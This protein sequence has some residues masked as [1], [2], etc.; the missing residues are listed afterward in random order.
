VDRSLEMIVGLLGILKAGGAYVPLDPSYPEE[1]LKYIVKDSGITI[2]LTKSN[3]DWWISKEVQTISLE[4][5]WEFISHGCNINPL[6]EVMPDNLAY[7]IYTSGSTG[8]PKGVLLEQKGLCNLVLTHIELMKVDAKSR[9]IQFASLSFDAAVNEVFTT[10]IAGATLYLCSSN[11]IMPKDPLTQF[12]QHNRITHA[13]LPP[14]VL[15]IL[16]ELDFKHLKVLISAGSACSE[17]IAQRWSKNCL[18]INGYGPTETTVCATIGIYEGNGKPH[19]GRPLPN[20]EVYVLDQNLQLVP[21]GVAGEL[22]IGGIALARGYLN[23]PELTAASFISHPFKG[24]AKAKIYKTGDLVKYLPNGNIEYMERIDNQVKIR[25]FRIELGEIEAVLGQYPSIKEVVVV[26]QDDKIGDKKL[27]AYVVGEGNVQEWKNHIQAHLPSY[28]IPSHF[29]NIESIPLTINGKVDKKSLPEWQHLIQNSKEYIPPRNDVERKLVVI[30]SEVLGI[31][32]SL[33]GVGDSF[34]ELGG[35]SLKIMA[36]LVKTLSEGWDISIKDYYELKTISKIAEKINSGPVNAIALPVS[37][38]Q[39]VKSPKKKI[40]KNK[41]CFDSSSGILLTGSTGYLGVHLLEKLMDATQN[42]IYCVVRGEDDQ[43]AIIRL[44]KMVK[45]YFKDK[46]KKYEALINKRLFIVKGELADKQFGLD[47]VR[48]EELKKQVNIVIHAAAL[49]KHFGDW[50]DFENANVQSVREIL[51]FVGKDKQLHHISTTSVSGEYTSDEGNIFT[52]NDSYIKQNYEDNVY[53]KSKFLAEQE[54][55]KAISEGTDANIY[56]V[57]NLTNRY[58]DGQ[59]QF[60]LEDNAFMNRFKFMLQYGVVTKDL[61]SDKVEFTPVDYCSEIIMGF[62]TSDK[63]D[64]YDN[65]CVFHIYNHKKVD[66]ENMLEVLNTLGYSIK[67]LSSEEYQELVLKLSQDINTQKDI[68]NLMMLGDLG[69]DKNK[70]VIVNSIKTQEKL[71]KLD[72]EWA[73]INEEY[74]E[75]IIHYMIFSK[76]LNRTP[77]TNV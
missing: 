26:A 71:K 63:I 60:N 49:T 43:Q 36:T 31:S 45:F 66:L 25:G 8:T 23:R 33:I 39:F 21:V 70:T 47:N 11:D 58:C 54:I 12:L 20:V 13:I 1:R 5:Q 72:T 55:F 67:L 18:F 29:V 42:K 41:K 51:K 19:I 69:K 75:K 32:S 40:A 44:T 34:F 6:V 65:D 73:S 53:V 74:L 3:T 52:E 24:E 10:L 59:H 68:R 48:Y 37:N 14:T 7:V 50:A 9:F 2:I 64:K 35:H 16:D 38:I 56:R 77:V 46:F 57:G 17:H 61:F 4:R 28:M 62:V 76:C 27:I 15:N 30:W 22:Y